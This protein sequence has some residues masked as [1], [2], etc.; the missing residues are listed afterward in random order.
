[1]ECDY[2]SL[3]DA[4]GEAGQFIRK[5]PCGWGKFTDGPLLSQ[6]DTGKHRMRSVERPGQSVSALT[7]DNT[8]VKS[9]LASRRT[10]MSCLARL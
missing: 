2:I 10:S 9:S 4:K 7:A 3:W 5:Y 6:F 1:M 8:E